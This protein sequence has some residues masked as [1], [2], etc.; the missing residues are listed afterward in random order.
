[1][2]KTTILYKDIA[3]GADEDATVTTADAQ[4]VST[5]SKLPAGV[6]TPPV[7]TCEL[8][9]WGL[10]GTFKAVDGQSLAFW[11]T[12]MTGADCA[13]TNGEE[14][15]ITITFSEQYSTVGITLQFDTATGGYCSAVNIKWYQQNALKADVDFQPDSDSYFCSK[16][17]ESYDK[18][19][20]TLKKTNLP[21]KY[22]K[23]EHIIF[24]IHRY[25]GMSELRSASVVNEMNLISAELPVS[26]FNW[27]LDSKDDV[28]FMF[29]LKQPVE[30][31]NDNNLIGVYYIDSF[32]R[33][34]K[35]VYPIECYDAF[36][37]LDEIPFSGAVYSA[38]S[39]KALIQ[40]LASPFEVEFAADVTD[41]TV[42]GAI[43][44]GTKRSAIQ[45]VLFA[46][47]VCAATDGTEKIRVFAP[48]ETAQVISKEKTFLGA[49]VDTDSIVTAVQ[50]K[51]HSY[52]Q[53]TSGSVEINGVKYTDTTA[54]Y[55]VSN[56][57]VTAND[58]Q[59]IVSI[60][61]ATLIS[62]SIGQAVAQRVYDYFQ[63]RNT[64]KAKIV[65]SGEKLGD[66]LTI[67]NSWGGTNVGNLAK[68]E[69]KIS[70]TVV[71]NG[72]SKGV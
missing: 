42:T 1:M 36:G 27:T 30:V 25:F 2:S 20:I 13:F 59:N 46:W 66:R 57:D 35:W 10:N 17:V 61:D 15:Q 62:P 50:V 71:Y 53:S 68:M 7:L 65:Y 56:A 40:T 26:K 60:T 8:N 11:S 63:R 14:P 43:L 39:A 29:Q 70:N 4:S 52:T 58:K 22:A 12:V 19:I 69:I 44:S 64:N 48:S 6:S 31:R 54:T 28:D 16:K 24:G 49:T 37:V 72:E 3:P 38:E 41:T 21:Y 34:S 47:G 32:S 67:Y 23:L 45:Q 18:L 9:Q 33:T 51:S 55:T 5:P